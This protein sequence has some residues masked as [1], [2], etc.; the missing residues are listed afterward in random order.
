MV[1]LDLPPNHKV[2]PGFFRAT[3]DNCVLRVV[4]GSNKY[5]L[6]RDIMEDYFPSNE[7]T[8]HMSSDSM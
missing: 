4:R 3:A 8:R 5:L 7:T 2:G 6:P 1:L